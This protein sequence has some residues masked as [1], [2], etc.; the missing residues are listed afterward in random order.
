MGILSRA[1]DARDDVAI[2]RHVFLIR[3]AG[4]RPRWFSP[5]GRAGAPP[6]A[7]PYGVTGQTNVLQF[8]EGVRAPAPMYSAADH[9]SPVGSA[10][11]AE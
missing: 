4:P 7:L 3:R 5:L 6:A 9:T 1:H 2:A 8:A 11:D 10:K